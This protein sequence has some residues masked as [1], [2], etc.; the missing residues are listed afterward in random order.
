VLLTPA[1]TM[2]LSYQRYKIKS[3]LGIKTMSCT[4]TDALDECLRRVRRCTQDLRTIQ[5]Q[6]GDFIHHSRSSFA[7]G[8]GFSAALSRFF[9]NSAIDAVTPTPERGSG[10]AQHS[11]PGLSRTKR[12]STPSPDLKPMDELFRSG[13]GGP[14][15]VGAIEHIT[16]GLQVVRKELFNTSGSLY[17]IVDDALVLN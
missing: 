15:L 3:N 16:E 13:C 10:S 6:L 9:K 7:A 17:I 11:A 2:A 5:C 1:R 4:S 14:P 8:R 12:A